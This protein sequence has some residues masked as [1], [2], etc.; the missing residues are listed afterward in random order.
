MPRA[1]QAITDRLIILLV[2]AIQRRFPT[3][4]AEVRSFPLLDPVREIRQ[5]NDSLLRF[6]RLFQAIPSPEAV[7]LQLRQFRLYHFVESGVFREYVPQ[8]SR[9]DYDDITWTTPRAPHASARSRRNF[10]PQPLRNPRTR[11]TRRRARHTSDLRA[12]APASFLIGSSGH[13]SVVRLIQDVDSERGAVTEA[14]EQ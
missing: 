1:R 12:N 8:L 2:H 7:E 9:Y 3:L 5:L 13:S 14:E 11:P 10:T 4:A 6:G